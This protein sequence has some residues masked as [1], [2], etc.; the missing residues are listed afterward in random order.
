MTDGPSCGQLWG[1]VGRMM[2]SP[3]SVKICICWMVSRKRSAT[4]RERDGCGTNW[5][6]TSLRRGEDAHTLSI[7]DSATAS[8]S[9]PSSKIVNLDRNTTNQYQDSPPQQ[10][11]ISISRNLHPHLRHVSSTL[12]SV[13]STSILRSEIVKRFRRFTQTLI[14][15]SRRRT[16]IKIWQRKQTSKHGKKIKKNRNLKLSIHKDTGS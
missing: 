10:H 7:R 14:D 6:R 8:R 11:S 5:K 12:D 3:V 13:I 16:E 1:F 4:A 15:Q 9:V 2:L